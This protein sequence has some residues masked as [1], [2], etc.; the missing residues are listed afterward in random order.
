MFANFPHTAA[1]YC[2][3]HTHFIVYL[4]HGL[5]NMPHKST[6]L[7]MTFSYTNIIFI[8]VFVCTRRMYDTLIINLR[9][10]YICFLFL[11]ML[12]GS[13]DGGAYLPR[14]PNIHSKTYSRCVCV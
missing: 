7:V 6:H 4:T 10:L 11:S 5:Q 13:N 14:F 12:N 9:C 2:N 1:Q 3:K 8:Y